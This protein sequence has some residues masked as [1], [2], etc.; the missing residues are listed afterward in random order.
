MW[1]RRVTRSAQAPSPVPRK[2]PDTADP[3]SSSGTHMSMSPSAWGRGRARACAVAAEAE[4]RVQP[5][6]VSAGGSL[7]DGGSPGGGSAAPG[8]SP[9]ERGSP[10]RAAGREGLRASTP[11]RGARRPGRGCWRVSVAGEVALQFAEA[12]EGA[13][14]ERDTAGAAPRGGAVAVEGDTPAV[15][16]EQPV[17][18][19]AHHDQ[20]LDD[21]GAAVSPVH[22]VMRVEVDTTPTTRKPPRIRMVRQR[23]PS[24]QHHAATVHT[25]V[26]T[27]HPSSM[28]GPSRRLVVAPSAPTPSTVSAPSGRRRPS[29]GVHAWRARSGRVRG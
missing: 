17:V 7:D 12:G 5:V 27:W 19:G 28:S 26:T 15:V 4:W 21:R 24:R 1:R 23:E 2:Q 18:V 14:D 8:G 25:A 11:R 6:A 3:E 10:A 22:D 9:V 29:R 20:V 16:V 13:G